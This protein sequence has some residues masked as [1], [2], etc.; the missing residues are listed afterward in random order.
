MTAFLALQLG[1]L[2]Q[3]QFA[4]GINQWLLPQWEALALEL[5]RDEAPPGPAQRRALE[6]LGAAVGREPRAL[7]LYARGRREQDVAQVQLAFRFM[8]DAERHE[9]AARRLLL[10]FE[11]AP[12]A[13]KR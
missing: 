4:D 13:A 5:H 3:R 6:L 1:N 12:A 2:S 7:V 11:R 9:A 10:D 8:G